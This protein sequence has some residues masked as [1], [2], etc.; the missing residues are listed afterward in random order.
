MSFVAD[1]A[2]L[3]RLLW[4]S[5]LTGQT[6]HRFVSLSLLNSLPQTDTAALRYHSL[7]IDGDVLRSQ[8]GGGDH[9]QMLMV[10]I[11]GQLWSMVWCLC[12]LTTARTLPLVAG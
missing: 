6:G 2:A 1:D 7:P 9:D 3:V 10:I 4:C 5:W 11:G 8:T 12:A